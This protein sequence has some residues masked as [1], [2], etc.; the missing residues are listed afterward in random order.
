MA[1]SKDDKIMDVSKPGKAAPSPSSKPIIV[2][3]RPMLKRD[4][5]VAT[6]DGLEK[7]SPSDD[8]VPVS[9]TAKTLNIVSPTEGSGTAVKV[10][11]AVSTAPSDS[12]AP[13][14]AS[15]AAS[16][17]PRAGAETPTDEPEQTAVADPAVPMSSEPAPATEQPTPTPDTM[18]AAPAPAPDDSDDDTDASE[19]LAPNQALEVAKQKEEAAKAAR[20]AEEEKIVTS[21]QYYLPIDNVEERRGFDRVLLV[22]AVVLI[23]ALVW[24]DVVLDAGIIHISGLHALT[25][26]FSH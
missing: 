8:T 22:L 2:T 20:L 15:N 10:V 1:T 12:V 3:N 23:L 9:R 21:R 4:P 18:P 5:M 24:A 16:S 13:P 25:H 19:Q 11:S 17:L 7:A 14:A 6:P 26:F